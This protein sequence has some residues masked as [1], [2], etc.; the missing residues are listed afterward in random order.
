M[1][2]PTP[3][4]TPQAL[5]LALREDLS[6]LALQCSGA[7]MWDWDV[8]SGEQTHSPLWEQ[9]LGYAPGEL[10]RSY[11]EFSSRLH[12]D[13]TAA[14]KAAMDE[15]LQGRS[16]HFS[17][18]LRLR[19]KDGSWT[20]VASRG[21]AVARDAQGQVLRMI[22]THVDI[23]ERKQAEAQLLELNARLVAQTDL[24]QSTLGNI[25]QGVFVFD[26]HK[27]LI[28][29]NSRACELLN[30]D[31]GFLALQPSLQEINQLQLAHNDFGPEAQG[32][33]ASARDYILSGGSAP[34][35]ARYLRTTQQGRTIKVKTRVLGHGGMVRTFADITEHVEA[36]KTSKRQDLLIHAI[37]DLAL[38]G[39]WEIDLES[40]RTF[41]TESTYRIFE[42]STEEFTPGNIIAAA[43]RFLP[44]ASLKTIVAW[45][46]QLQPAITHYDFEL[47]AL[48]M[49]GRKIW[50]RS[51]GTLVWRDGRL[52]TLTSVIQ[53]ITEQKR[54]WT[55]LQEAEDR[56]KL[57]LENTGDGVWDWDI[58]DGMEYYSRGLL[59][60]YG[61]EDDDR[62]IPA[63]GSAHTP[64]NALADPPQYW[65]I[66]HSSNAC[67]V[68]PDDAESMQ[69]TL[70]R[71][72]DGLTP[73]YL[74]EHRLR[75]RDGSWK[76]IMSR[77][78]VVSRAADKRPLRMIGTHSDISER[79]Q[80]E[81]LIRQQALFDPLTGL[82]NRRTLADRLDQEIR[83]C[84]RDGQQLAVLFIDLDHFKEVN[85]TL[86]HGSGDALLVE[87]ARRIQHCLRE[88]D[89]VARM[90]GDEFTVI[91]TD[92]SDSGRLQPLLQKILH[93]LGQAFELGSERA[94]V[95]ASIGITV[96][97]S[98]GTE[99]DDLFK[100][101][102]QALYA[103][104]GAGRNRYS[105][106]TPSLQEAAQKRLRLVNDMRTAIA[107]DQFR[108]VYQPMVELATGSIHKAEALIRWQHPE[109]GLISPADFIPVA[110]TSGL[111]ASIGDWV[112]A[113]A[114][115]QVQQ[116][117]ATLHPEFQISVNR[118]PVQ[119]QNPGAQQASWLGQMQALDLPKNCLVMEI[120]EGL[121]LD[122]SD[123]LAQQLAAL[124]EA[125]VQ[126][127]LD[128]F[129]T[130][131]S[132][133][134]YL[135][136]FK[137]D[138]IKID[139]SFIRQ[140]SHGSTSLALCK[141]IIVMAHA[142]GMK[143]V[144]EGVETAEQCAPLTQAG[145][146]YGQGYLFSRP[147]SA[148]EFDRLPGLRPGP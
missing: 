31:A 86:G 145:C 120:T 141:A 10:R 76:W 147:V 20:W 38:V 96:Y 11:H 60:L 132:S 129:G 15:Y 107:Q 81:A 99:I 55:A 94:F 116:W 4:A 128:D 80:T 125:G 42:T 53:D 24:L 28:S 117:R 84:K 119:F 144:A 105:F 127:S 113:H 121:L 88:T 139:Q 97:P 138:F 41:W 85:D 67:E 122:S 62:F 73:S 102:D 9:M 77:G 56:W 51:A 25:S 39:G 130:G 101:A 75:C 136:K 91:L 93:A 43:E 66:A 90:G 59:H 49:K 118:S 92:I 1:L 48:T 64:G 23:N 61:F 123:A 29:F 30:L 89:T 104:K 68:H 8:A 112:F 87:A 65:R 3:T 71:H 7:A 103:A 58:A 142:L 106:F 143:V 115:Q 47:E 63:A 22:G 140:L 82:P 108:V 6:K 69:S 124:Q 98:D 54:S 83:R 52:A 109:R 95:S 12:Q 2:P 16:P 79:K 50:V 13:D 21:L 70:Q 126:V 72:L 133:L 46:G 110:E 40:D 19:R 35:P 137:I 36:Q 33:E 26:V 134:A 5:D 111:I 27:K 78:M 135:Q 131:Y 34:P 57:A 74:H 44:Q 14:V 17:C 146:D 100:N 37:Q 148:E 18:D 32:V 45:Y 114:A